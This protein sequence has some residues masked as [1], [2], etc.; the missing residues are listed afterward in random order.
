MI[1]VTVGSAK[2]Y[3]FIRLLKLIDELCEENFLNGEEVFAQV[4]YNDYTPKNY[5]YF[6]MVSDV[7]FKDYLNKA[8]IIISHAGTGTVVASVKKGKKVVIFPRLEKYNEHLDDH[9][10][11]ISELFSEKGYALSALNKQELIEAIKALPTFSPNKFSSGN[12]KINNLIIEFL[13]D[14]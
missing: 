13:Y 10:L 11:E 2:E 3:K 5:N 7:E 12:K 9:Q 1:L 4:G 8:E 14:R 6:D